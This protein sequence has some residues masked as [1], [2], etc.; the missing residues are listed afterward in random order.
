MN[1]GMPEQAVTA[2][3]LDWEDLGMNSSVTNGLKVAA[4]WL[5]LL[6][7]IGLVSSEPEKA[8]AAQLDRA[9]TQPQGEQEQRHII[10]LQEAEEG[11]D[12][13]SDGG[14]RPRRTKFA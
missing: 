11:E 3:P 14:W 9:I 8:P 6:G 2:H 7:V 5:V 4:A 12:E 10:P 1:T 13:K